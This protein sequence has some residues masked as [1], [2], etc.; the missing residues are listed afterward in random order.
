MHL[1]NADFIGF[2]GRA[3]LKNIS[4]KGG[5]CSPF[6]FLKNF[7]QFCLETQ[8][9]KRFTMSNVKLACIALTGILFFACGSEKSVDSST[10]VDFSIV[11]IKGANGEYQYIDV[12]QKG[13]IV[14]NPQFGD[15]RI[16][17]DGLALVKTTGKGGK[18]GYIDKA[19][20][21]AISPVYVYAQ[22]FGE[23]VAWVQAEDKIPT[24][25]NKK[26]ETL[27]QMDS[28]TYAYPFA[29]GMAAIKYY[30][31]GEEYGNFIDKKGKP[32]LPAPIKGKFSP[33]ISDGLYAFQ[34]EDSKKWG[35]KNIKGEIVIKEQFDDLGKDNFYAFLYEASGVKLGGKYGIINKKGEYAVNPQYDDLLEDSDG[36]FV[37][38]SG[39]KAGWINKNGEIVVNLQ[40]DEAF[41]FLGSKLA[42]VQIGDKMGYV[43]RK[44][45]IEINPQ[46]LAALPFFGD[47][48]VVIVL[49]GRSV[50]V[51]FIDQKGDFV[52]APSYDVNQ[53]D[54]EFSW[55]YMFA[56][57]Q[58]HYGL[59]MR[60]FY[61]PS[62]AKFEAK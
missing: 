20:K 29:G 4:G 28:L 47:Y 26:G 21:Y 6:A 12:S 36:L 19:G 38:K 22:D 45:Q 37:V 61:N 53:K 52:V 59:P 17:R 27:L 51:G 50:K 8:P 42:V 7:K 44:G 57:M 31:E 25:I 40:F 3:A 35:F 49:D 10:D 2:V 33:V 56:I 11:P 23:G 13:K 34:S 18:Y 39:K 32:V 43:D 9:T 24:L 55:E 5:K 62:N 1:K 58:K 54:I 30:S 41:P 60:Y 15:A 14:I 48:A 16:F 46:F